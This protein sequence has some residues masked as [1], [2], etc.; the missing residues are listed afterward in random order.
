MLKITKLRVEIYSFWFQNQ[1]SFHLFW[2]MEVLPGHP[3][4]NV[5]ISLHVLENCISKEP[6]SNCWPNI[7]YSYL[8][9]K[10][11]KPLHKQ[12]LVVFTSGL[13]HCQGNVL[14]IHRCRGAFLHKAIVPGICGTGQSFSNQSTLRLGLSGSDMAVL[15]HARRSVPALI[16]C[17]WEF[18]TKRPR[19]ASPMGSQVSQWGMAEL[20]F[21]E[22]HKSK[23][24]EER[25]S[26]KL[27]SLPSPTFT[28]RPAQTILSIFLFLS[29]YCFEKT[30]QFCNAV[31]GG[32][33][34]LTVCV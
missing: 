2:K 26:Y 27:P 32:A 20:P 12:E 11:K 33:K 34:T 13:Q 1:C 3:K 14:I 17:L 15:C 29:F 28:P 31:L 16:L 18:G 24:P 4:V 19:K 6:F 25:Q 22:K 5:T 10:N 9:P 8:K 30:I 7:C 23:N 21:R